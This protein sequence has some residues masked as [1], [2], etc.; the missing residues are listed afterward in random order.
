MHN[1]F[2]ILAVLIQQ[3]QKNKTLLAADLVLNI[4]ELMLR[5]VLS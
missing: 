3:Q 2:S 1:L 5:F 4:T